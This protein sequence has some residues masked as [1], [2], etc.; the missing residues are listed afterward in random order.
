MVRCSNGIEGGRVVYFRV[1]GSLV[2]KMVR[3]PYPIWL[4]SNSVCCGHFAGETR[5]FER[6]FL[7]VDAMRVDPKNHGR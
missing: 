3:S 4:R 7:S 5:M 2:D 6:F 1:R